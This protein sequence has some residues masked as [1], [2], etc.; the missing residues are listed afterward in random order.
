MI[1]GLKKGTVKLVPHN[2]KWAALFEK[3][4]KILQKSLGD[5]IVGIEHVGS[6]SIKNICA[7]PILDINVGVKSVKYFEKVSHI[8]EKLG[9]ANIKN[10]NSSH[11]HLVFAKGN[12]R[13]GTTHYV[14]VIK[15]NGSLWEN[16]VRFRDYLRGHKEVAQQYAELKKKLALTHQNDRMAYTENK[17]SFIKKFSK[18]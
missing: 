8:L 17:A 9:Y 1:L 6:T 15:Y 5:A 11:V 3:E 16:D 18:K 2:K 14:H 12:K 7:K 13:I 10:K 4:K